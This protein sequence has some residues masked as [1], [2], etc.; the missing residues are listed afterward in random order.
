MSTGIA[1]TVSV[2]GFHAGEVASALV[3][4]LP[5]DGL[6]LVLVFADWRIDS[7][8]LARRLQQSFSAPV[9]GCTT[10]GVVA[11]TRE[12][13]PSAA[14]IGLYGDWVR[15]GIGVATDLPK[16]P[17]ARSRDAV[18]QAA[19]ALGTP[20]DA[21]E[22]TRHVA[23]TLVDGSCG[24]EEAFCIASAA[25]SPQIRFVGGSAATEIGSKRRSYV[26]VNGETLVD[27]GVV[28]LLES[29]LPFE[30]ITSQHMIATEAK[31]VVT[32]ASGRTLEELDGRPAAERL[33]ELVAQLGGTLDKAKPSE[34]A[35]ARF[36]DNVPYI[37]SM[38]GIEG[39]R[40]HLACAVEPGPVL[41]LMRPGDLIA[42][43]RQDLAGVAE[44]VGG[45]LSA[46][47]AFSCIGRHWAAAARGIEQPL[48]DTYALYPTIGFQSFGE[49]IGMLLVNHTLTG[50]AIGARR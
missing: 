3:A 40:V 21:L 38:I 6:K 13:H 8:Q 50:L 28:I 34:Y 12:A 5:S 24:H 33:Q 35:F 7:G 14:A 48:A 2:S 4:G 46:L 29:K 27:A 20:V 9:I 41:R 19:A 39:T 36:V 26:W 1:R 49:Q 17:L 47:L 18:H 37:R 45:E 42:Q 43:T 15:I 10:I 16:S 23:I 44:R 32:A 25:T 22:L 31:T 30:A 11:G